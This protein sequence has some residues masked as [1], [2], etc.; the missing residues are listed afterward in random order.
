MTNFCEMQKRQEANHCLP[1]DAGNISQ[2]A[3][4]HSNEM[5]IV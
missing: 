2:E 1:A 3:V 5:L 4:G